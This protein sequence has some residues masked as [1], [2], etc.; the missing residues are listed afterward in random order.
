MIASGDPPDRS[1]A[2][3]HP[4]PAARSPRRESE[5]SAAGDRDRDRAERIAIQALGFIAADPERLDRF[6]ALS[7]I[8]PDTLREA[9]ATQGFLASTLD[10]LSADET[11]LLAFAAEAGLTPE[12]VAA[13]RA[14]L[15]GDASE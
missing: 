1:A 3:P 10:H 13:A 4:K 8:T 7:G 2:R 9:A 12:G 6:L 5:R 14:I 11:A 15:A